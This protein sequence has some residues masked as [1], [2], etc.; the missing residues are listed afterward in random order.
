PFAGTSSAAIFDAILNKQPVSPLRLNPALPDELD[1]IIRKALE[2]DRDIRSQS[3]AE[4]RAD[5]KRLKRDTSSDRLPPLRAATVRSRVKLWLRASAA[6]ASAFLLA[7]ALWYFFPLPGPRVTATAQITD[8][9]AAKD[10]LVTDGARIYFTEVSSGHMVLAQVSATGGETSQISTPFR[11]VLVA[12]ISPDHSQLLLITLEGT[13]LEGPVWALPLPS[14]SP[15][16]LRDLKA[17]S[18]S[19]SPD[20]TRLAFTLGNSVYLA[21]ADGSESRLLTAVKGKPHHPRFSPDGYR[22]RFTIDDK[23]RLA[24]SLWE[25]G[26]DGQRLRPVFPGWHDPPTEC[27][28]SW[29]PDGRYF[30]FL[31]GTNRSLDVYALADRASLF[32][33]ASPHPVQLTAGPLFYYFLA[34][35]TDARKIF[36]Q[37]IQPRTQVVRFDPHTRLFVPYLRGISATDLSFSCDGQWV[38]YVSVPDGILWRS[39]IDG[40]DRVQLSYP[41]E[42]AVLPVWSADATRIIYETFSVGKGWGARIVSVQ[43]GAS[44]DALPGGVGGVDFNWS[45]DG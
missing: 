19:W 36:I 42:R 10:Y 20:M 29:T 16:R 9:G 6:L 26:A 32:R 31:S 17:N 13:F 28:G 15:R 38:A 25:I 22:I 18:A 1:H 45:P 3:A 8:D 33:R 34:P 44:E 21:N 40:S 4:I 14:G 41:P 35:S 12:D 37:A 30:I 2:K 39:R 7:A 23:D 27:C 11:N 43:G 5:L 24:Y